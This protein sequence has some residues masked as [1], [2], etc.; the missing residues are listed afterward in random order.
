MANRARNIDNAPGTSQT[1]SEEEVKALFEAL[2]LSTAADRGKFLLLE[3]FSQDPS[4]GEDLTDDALLV[5]FR[6]CTA[7]DSKV[8]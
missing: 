3:R 5:R 2:N 6:D 7:S 8:K 4:P 1:L